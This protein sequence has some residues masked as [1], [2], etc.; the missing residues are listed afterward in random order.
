MK[1]TIAVVLAAF[2]LLSSCKKT[3]P[4]ADGIYRFSGTLTVDGLQRT[5][6]LNLPPNYYD[7]SN[8]ALVIAMHGGGGSATQFEA[9]NK[10]TDKANTAHFAVVYPNG[11]E[12]DGLLKARTWNAGSCC[13]YAVRQ[14]I[15]DVKFISVLIDTLLSKYK[16]NSKKVFATGHSNGGMMSY[17]LACEL[18]D[19]IAGIAPNAC[20]MVV[21][22]C[23]PSKPVPVLHMHSVNDQNV[24]Y[25]G[26]YGNGTGTTGLW[27]APVDSVLTV[28]ASKNTCAIGPTVIT[29]DS[30]FKYTKWSSCNKNNTID[31]Y[32]TTDGGHAWPGG[33]KGSAIGDD[34]STFINANDLLWEFF[35][36]IVN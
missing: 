2:I 5:Y 15:N 21:S 1:P 9:T 36:K 28:W 30:K 23:N 19:K 6:M 22:S 33:L 11:V 14:N 8:F 25:K 32:L 4:P 26:G 24:P 31:Y 10:L 13:D 17:R 27:L 16:I 3:V 12:G 20:T 18:S 35:S 34:P 7:S 29:N